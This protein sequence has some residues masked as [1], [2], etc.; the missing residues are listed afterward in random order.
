[1]KKKTA[2]TIGFIFAIIICFS[3]AFAAVHQPVTEISNARQSKDI[4]S[5]TSAIK[6]PINS[7]LKTFNKEK[8]KTYSLKNSSATP[9]KNKKRVKN[10]ASSKKYA[11]LSDVLSQFECKT[12]VVQVKVDGIIV[13]K[14]VKT[15]KSRQDG[16]WGQ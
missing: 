14:Y 7:E 5:K 16:S 2:K 1:M 3:I 10:S 12:V 4:V 9:E 6:P 15:C 11:A 13:E 8:V